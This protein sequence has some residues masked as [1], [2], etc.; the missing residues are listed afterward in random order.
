MKHSTSS[1]RW[2]NE[3]ATDIYVKKA[4]LDGYRSRAVYKLLELH[5]KDKLLKPGMVVVDLG[6]APGSWSQLVAKKVAPNGHVYAIDILEMPPI[7]GVTFI[8]GDFTEQD[9]LD[10]LL[11]A[12]GN[13][14][15]DLILSDMAPSLTGIKSV[16]QPRALYLEELA[17]ALS[18]HVL[19]PGGNLLIKVFHGAGLEQ[20]TQTMR[21]MFKQV[22]NRKPKASR[23]RSSEAYLLA[24]GYNTR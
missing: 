24:K 1:N 6:A 23:S 18:E 21:S 8:Q 2:L 15:A 7:P 13:V 20:L 11:K 12:M 17:L 5:E 16:D 4:Q 10:N 3:H 19:K 22:L 14:K 9:V